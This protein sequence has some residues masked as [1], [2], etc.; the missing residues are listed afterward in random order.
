MNVPETS[1]AV[2]LRIFPVNELS[3]D[4]IL[5]ISKVKYFNPIRGSHIH[6][7]ANGVL[8]GPGGPT[9]IAG[10]IFNRN[11]HIPNSILAGPYKYG[12]P[13]GNFIPGM[14]NRPY[15]GPY[16]AGPAGPYG[17]AYGNAYENY[18]RKAT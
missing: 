13:G 9:G 14:F 11:P 17:N 3:W 4:F 12:Y 15:G 6:S 7:A 10:P 8:V 18:G 5:I 2:Y 16:G 1:G